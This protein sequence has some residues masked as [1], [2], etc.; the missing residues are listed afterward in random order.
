MFSPSE[1]AHEG[2]DSQGRGVSSW[3]ARVHL[4]NALRCTGDFG[5]CLMQSQESDSMILVGSF[6][7]R[8]FCDSKWQPLLLRRLYPE[9]WHHLLIPRG[10]G[11][12]VP[13]VPFTAV[14][15][16]VP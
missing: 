2:G 8:I 9:G 4:D 10:R 14:L 7:H 12:W 5:G 1:A 3:S 11:E 6:Q 13:A 16:A 15:G